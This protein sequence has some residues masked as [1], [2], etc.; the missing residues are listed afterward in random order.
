MVRRVGIA[1]VPK[2][3]LIEEVAKKLNGEIEK[4]VWM[5]YAKTGAHTERAPTR[6]DWFYVRMASIL[7]K[8]HSWGIIGTEALRSYYGGRKNRGVKREHHY[9]ASGKVIR[10][11]VQAL[12]KKGYLEK[13]TPKGRKLSSKGF[14][15]LNELSKVVEKN[16]KENAYAKKPK[17]K[18]IFDEKKKKEVQETLKRQD[19]GRAKT[20]EEKSQK[21]MKK[22][23]ES[24]A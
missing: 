22:K 7:C 20:T 11:C 14:K 2:E 8:A 24:D 12:E 16:M 23:K 13:A 5:N 15:L 6:Q 18:K 21:V 4:P 10:T 3:Y 17:V 1:D 9:K 19:K